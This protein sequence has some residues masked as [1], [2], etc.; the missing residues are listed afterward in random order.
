MPVR[1]STLRFPQPWTPTTAFPHPM[2]G[3]DN[4][5]VGGMNYKSY[6][7]V[8]EMMWLGKAGVNSP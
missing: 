5:Q 4:E 1:T 3:L 6:H 2:S 7:A 8:D